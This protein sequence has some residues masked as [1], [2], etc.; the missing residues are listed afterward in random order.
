MKNPCT[1][2]CAERSATCHSK[3]KP[4]LEFYAENREKDKARVE[5]QRAGN[6]LR[7]YLMKQARANN[8]QRKVADI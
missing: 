5:Y 7:D 6:L 2:D 1:K 3:C 8:K 4:Y